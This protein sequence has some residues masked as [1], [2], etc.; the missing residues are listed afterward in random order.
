MNILPELSDVICRLLR[1]TGREGV[2]GLIFQ[3]RQNGYFQASCHRHH[4][5]VGGMAQ[6][7]FEVYLYMKEHIPE[8]QD[9]KLTILALLHDLCD[10]RG[11]HEYSGHGR[12]SVALLKEFGF[13]IDEEESRLI[14]YH[15]FRVSARTPEEEIAVKETHA[16]REWQIFKNADCYSA[17]NPMSAE[18]TLNE[19]ERLK[20]NFTS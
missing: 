14:R 7:A 19:I 5:Y 2:E 17:K 10:I 8:M 1:A 12:R 6:H 13:N 20:G 16:S 9:D 3:M 4:Y 11:F 18:D 15:M